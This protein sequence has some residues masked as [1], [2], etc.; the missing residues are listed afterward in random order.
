MKASFALLG[1][2]ALLFLS[3]VA[4]ATVD[5][6]QKYAI[7]QQH[8]SSDATDEGPN[9]CLKPSSFDSEVGMPFFNMMIAVFQ[10]SF[11]LSVGSTTYGP[12]NGALTAKNVPNLAKAYYDANLLSS[13]SIR[14]GWDAE[15]VFGEELVNGTLVKTYETSVELDMSYVTQQSGPSAEA[16]QNVV[17]LAKLAIVSIMES[18]KLTVSRTPKIRILV[19]GLPKQDGLVGA[20][21]PASPQSPYTPTSPLLTQFKKETLRPGCQSI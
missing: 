1:S 11:Q 7:P 15:E 8:S 14:F 3:T 12:V 13:K 17:N 5:V 9:V 10:P 6:V 18:S 2:C 19:K 21:V 4:N 16:R 20:K